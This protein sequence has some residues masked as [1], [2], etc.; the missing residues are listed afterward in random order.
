MTALIVTGGILLF[1]M[2]LLFSPIWVRFAYQGENLRASVHYL[3]IKIDFSPENAAKRAE[4][5]AARELKKEYEKQKKEEETKNKK[6]KAAEDTIKTVWSLIKSCKKALDKIRR[7][8]IF[9]KIKAAIVVGGDEARKIALNYATFCALTANGI[10]VL[11]ALFTV[12]EPEIAIR[13]D[14]LLEKTCINLTFRVRIALWYVLAAAL[15]ILVRFLKVI[16]ADKQKRKKIKG[17][18]NNE[19]KAY[20][21]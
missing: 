18:N 21:K 3:F 14:F 20:C 12:R 9:Y 7:H 15:H 5:K 10:A 19:R 6:E 16:S 8:I 2:I 11:D 13:P 17:G 4:K 1:F